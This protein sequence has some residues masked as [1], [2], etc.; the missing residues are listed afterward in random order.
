[1]KIPLPW[2]LDVCDIIGNRYGFH[3]PEH[4]AFILLKPFVL[5]VENYVLAGH[6]E[7]GGQKIVLVGLSIVALLLEPSLEFFEILAEQVFPA[8]LLPS[9]EMV[10]LGLWYQSVFFENPVNLLLLAPHDIPFIVLSLYLFPLSFHEGLVDAVPE[11]GLE[12]YA[13]TMF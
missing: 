1:M 2:H 7:G 4:L 10:D 12:P 9:S 13:L 5:L 8:K 6:Q 11:G 3:D